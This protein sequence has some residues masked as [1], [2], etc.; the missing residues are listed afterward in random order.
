MQTYTPPSLA[1]LLK[2]PIFTLKHEDNWHAPVTMKNSPSLPVH[3]T[4]GLPRKFLHPRR[5]SRLDRL[6]IQFLCVGLISRYYFTAYS[7]CYGAGWPTAA[8]T[9]KTRNNTRSSYDKC[10]SRSAKIQKNEPNFHS[11]MKRKRQ[12]KKKRKRERWE[13][14]ELRAFIHHQLISCLAYSSRAKCHHDENK[15]E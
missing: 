1:C 12:K 14:N 9:R 5:S 4:Q 11:E 6:H 8:A 3:M 15:K 13:S 10:E 7:S 2:M